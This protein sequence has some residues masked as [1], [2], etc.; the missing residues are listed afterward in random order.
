M[1]DLQIPVSTQP[2]HQTV[3]CPSQGSHES[4]IEAG[5]AARA[6][7]R[8]TPIRACVKLVLFIAAC[9]SSPAGSAADV[10]ATVATEFSIRASRLDDALSRFGAQ[11]GLQV[12]YSPELVRGLNAPELTGRHNVDQALGQLLKGTGLTWRYVNG[13]T[14]ALKRAEKAAEKATADSAKKNS[15]TDDTAVAEEVTVVGKIPEILV[16]GSRS[17]NADI[18][19]TE[20]DIQPYVVFDQQQIEAVAAVN[21]EEFFK[22]R[23]PMNTVSSTWSQRADTINGNQSQINLRGLGTNQTLIL[24]NGRRL[25][26]VSNIVQNSQFTQPDINGIP[27]SAVERIEVLPSTASGIYGGGATGGV[28][29]IIL[30]QNFAGLEMRAAY[31]GTFEGGGARRRVDLNGGLSL[32]DG[33]TRVMFSASYSDQAPLFSGQRD[34]ARKSRE[35]LLANDPGSIYGTS[36]PPVG[37]T[38]NIKNVAAGNLVLDNG[39]ALASNI[40]FV[41][42]GY[43][44]V[45]S[46]GG[47]ALAAKAGSYNLDM[48]NTLSGRRAA[49]SSGPRTNA[50]SVDVRRNFG[51]R[52]EAFLDLGRNE[53][54]GR[55]NFAYTPQ[56]QVRLAANAPNNPFTTTVKVTY[57]LIV[58][59]P[60]SISKTETLRALAG[61]IIRLPSDWTTELDY[62]WSRSRLEFEG[63]DLIFNE[64]FRPALS[65]GTLDVMRDLNAFP[66][67]TSAYTLPFPNEHYGPSDTVLNDLTLR[68]AGPT[69]RLPAGPIMLSSLVEHR[70]Q[71]AK[72]AYR[73][74]LDNGAGASFGQPFYAYYYPRLQTVD[75]LYLEALVPLISATNAQP[76]VRQLE[77][78]LSARRDEYT[79]RSLP[80]SEV[81]RSSDTSAP[82]EPTYFTNKIASRGDT[83]GL[84]YS[85]APD[86]ILRASYS[87]GF[88]P[89]AID[90]IAPSIFENVDWSFNLD[91]KRGFT[92]IGVI[93]LAQDG[94]T[95]S[96]PEDSKSWSGGV[97]LTPR[98]LPGLRLS[99]D[100][101]KIEKT[102]ELGYLSTGELLRYEELFPERIVRGALSPQDAALGYTAGPIT[103][104]FEGTTN[105]AH[106]LVKALD[107]QAD[108]A[109]STESFGSFS[110][111]ALATK[112]MNSIRQI[113]IATPALDYVGVADGPLLWRGNA[114][115]TWNRGAWTAGWSTQYFDSYR[116]GGPDPSS[117]ELQQYLRLQGSTRVPSQVYH[118]LFAKYESGTSPLF[119][120]DLLENV[121]VRLSIQNVLDKSP[122]ISART[123]P[124]GGYDSYG[125][126]RLRAYSVSL[127]KRW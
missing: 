68:L 56:E 38:S 109:W 93:T 77:L 102:N 95:A 75:S 40:T 33:K 29:N 84:R 25:P 4:G 111:F 15:K 112:Q 41:P 107:I 23:L 113:A 22:T 30:K 100:F 54:E 21:L 124:S 70:R 39:T 127:R 36:Y 24:V 18:R 119:G 79:T 116:L 55:A 126:P 78:Q 106:T 76:G 19:R 81:L 88:L 103:E 59:K 72:G 10:A 52:L 3:K 9:V 66:F 73:R 99:L 50:I 104:I 65:A 26:D 69:V 57:P 123:F 1:V 94:N 121:E 83:L 32:G 91:P 108:Y 82:S 7:H 48:P 2:R 45:A 14:V 71:V 122:P 98:F 51:E 67:D 43:A 64:N 118:D 115:L 6:V 125:D 96:K 16:N 62:A 49:L 61:V 86:L 8:V 42:I 60:E 31:D 120:V 17:L 20:D 44:G 12:V 37:Y 117:E 85:P 28:I 92:P 11:S 63:A 80:Q 46:D 110:V 101:T 97:I 5:P 53:N 90:Q 34:F 114:G 27:I 74:G 89:P 87:T 58:D 13:N 105:F 47:A 35:K